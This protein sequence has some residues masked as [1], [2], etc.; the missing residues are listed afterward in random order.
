MS[1]K[2]LYKMA[3]RTK[4]KVSGDEYECDPISTKKIRD[5]KEKTLIKMDL[6][7]LPFEPT[8]QKNDADDEDEEDN[9][10]K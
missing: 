5:T 2:K 7:N 9:K 8:E 4:K 10:K 3:K 6:Q 1:S